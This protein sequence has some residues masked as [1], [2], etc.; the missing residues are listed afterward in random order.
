MEEE[1]QDALEVGKEEAE[2]A[3]EEDEAKGRG[4]LAFS[5]LLSL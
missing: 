2:K 3:Q 4:A 5:L 1:K